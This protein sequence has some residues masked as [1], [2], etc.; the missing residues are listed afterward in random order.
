V[1]GTSAEVVTS[2]TLNEV[3]GAISSMA[4]FAA[5]RVTEGCNGVCYA[6][7]C[8]FWFSAATFAATSGGASEYPWNRCRW[9][10]RP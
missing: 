1:G 8:S 9:V 7:A 3:K 4:P 2:A 10:P 6:T 5:L